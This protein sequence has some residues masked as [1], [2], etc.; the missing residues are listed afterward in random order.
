VRE[1]TSLALGEYNGS[2]FMLRFIHMASACLVILVALVACVGV[3]PAS[4]PTSTNVAVTPSPLL[5]RGE[6]VSLVKAWVAGRFLSAC[7]RAVAKAL[8]SNQWSST[9]IEKGIWEVYLA[10]YKWI[11]YEHSLLIDAADG[12]LECLRH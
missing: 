2:W 3:T 8:E 12:P 7:D 1:A 9:R 4:N 5:A 6:A 11:V 10:D